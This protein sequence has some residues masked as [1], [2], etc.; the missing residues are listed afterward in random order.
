[1]NLVNHIISY[2]YRWDK[3]SISEARDKWQNYKRVENS[4]IFIEHK[5]S[6]SIIRMILTIYMDFDPLIN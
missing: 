2:A 6:L 3:M 1:M 4:Q 5:F